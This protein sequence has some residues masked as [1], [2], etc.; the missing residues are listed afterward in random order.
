MIRAA[1]IC[2]LYTCNMRLE[3]S[4]ALQNHHN[5][6]KQHWMH[7]WWS[8]KHIVKWLS[9][10]ETLLC[11]APSLILLLMQ[12]AAICGYNCALRFFSS[13]SY[14]RFWEHSW[15]AS[16]EYS[17]NMAKAG[18]TCT[19]NY[20]ALSHASDSC[21]SEHESAPCLKH[22]ATVE[23]AEL[24]AAFRTL[25]CICIP[26]GMQC[27]T[28]T[29]NEGCFAANSKRRPKPMPESICTPNSCTGQT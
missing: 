26:T 15:R 25:P 9:C 1:L 8:I 13:S 24:G 29:Y 22:N 18:E 11:P 14:C 10:I 3:C 2:K 20:V 21:R 17:Q 19:Y 6:K 27:S 5:I 28:V 7:R 12:Q 4:I 16:S 23:S